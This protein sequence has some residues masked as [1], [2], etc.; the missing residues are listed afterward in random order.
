M[1]VLLDA[2]CSYF[3]QLKPEN[4]LN[5]SSYVVKRFRKPKFHTCLLFSNKENTLEIPR[6]L[7]P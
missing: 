6:M 5:I 2:K 7:L 4:V 1:D 3:S